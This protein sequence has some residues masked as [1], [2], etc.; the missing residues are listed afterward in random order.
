LKAVPD[1]AEWI[2]A[3]RSSGS[4]D[5]PAPLAPGRERALRSKRQ[6]RVIL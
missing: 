5:M 1:P 2:R 3:M 4:G 6:Q